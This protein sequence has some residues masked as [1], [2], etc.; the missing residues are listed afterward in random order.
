MLILQIAISVLI[1][2]FLYEWLVG[3]KR[4]AAQKDEDDAEEAEKW[5]IALK[6]R[7]RS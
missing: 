1:G 3:S 4:L 6:K 5:M 2:N 7:P